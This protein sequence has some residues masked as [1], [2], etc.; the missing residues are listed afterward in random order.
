MGWKTLQDYVVERGYD[1]ERE[2]PVKIFIDAAAR[3]LIDEKHWRALYQARCKTSHS[4]DEE[5]AD[6]I[7]ENIVST[8][9][10]IF[11]QLETRMQLEKINEQKLGEQTDLGFDADTTK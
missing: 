2:K 10:G 3:G 8:Y 11:I 5:I 9:H 1:G 6:Q 7:A 4:Y